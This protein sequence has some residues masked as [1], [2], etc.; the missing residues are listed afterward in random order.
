MKLALN[1]IKDCIL[2]EKHIC[3]GVPRPIH[4]FREL[5][6]TL[7]LQSFMLISVV[8]VLFL[9]GPSSWSSGAILAPMG[10]L[11]ISKATN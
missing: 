1:F 2:I 9:S 8:G 6:P 4:Q 3:P 11:N 7:P 5:L 10:V